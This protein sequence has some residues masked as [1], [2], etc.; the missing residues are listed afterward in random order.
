MPIDLYTGQPGNGKT[1]HM[2]VRLLED[3]EKVR[4][5]AP[6]ARPV[7]AS[8]IDG[9]NVPGVELLKDPREW[10]AVRPG[11]VCTCDDPEVHEDCTAH[12]IP[13]GSVIYV[14]E[15]WKHFGHLQDASRA[16]NPPHVLKLAEHRHRGIDFVWTTQMPNQLFPFARGL[17]GSHTHVVRRFGTHWVD[18]FTWGELQEDVKS[19]AKRELANRKSARLPKHV[20]DKYKSA[21]LHTIKRKLPFKVMVLPL[22]VVGAIVIGWIAYQH[23]KPD[24]ISARL[25]GKNPDSAQAEPGSPGG[26]T[27]KAPIYRTAAEYAAAFTPRI[28]AAP[29]TAPAYDGRAVVS[30]P[31][32][33]CMISGR[34]HEDGS[35]DADAK[36]R[37]LTEQGTRYAMPFPQCRTVVEAGGVYNP[38]LEP[39]TEQRSDAPAGA[40]AGQR[41]AAMAAPAAAPVRGGGERAEQV[42]SYG[43]IG[44]TP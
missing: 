22:L 19:Q 32:A 12:V 28:A 31:T 15:A 17:I 13:N 16:P 41:P 24:S 37:C 18:L 21:T 3:A 43:A 11:A 40:G 27:G 42:A 38:F 23:L 6:D 4:T 35:Y 5:G 8:G 30:K 1:A 10:N 44:A 39:A 36:C 9:L 7:W 34:R 14:D 25:Q 26:G 29:W 20:F 33:V 2:M